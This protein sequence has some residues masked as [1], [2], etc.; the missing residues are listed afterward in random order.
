MREVQKAIKYLA[1]VFGLFL[2][3]NIIAW[4]IFGITLIGGTIEG[5]NYITSRADNTISYSETFENVQSL[6]IKLNA[7]ELEIKQGDCFKVEGNKISENAEIKLENS[8]LKITDERVNTSIWQNDNLSKI[9]VYIPEGTNL[10]SSNIKLGA[11]NAVIENIDSEK[12]DFEFGAGNVTL[13]NIYS[14]ESN[15][16]CGAGNIKVENSNL[17]NLKLKAGVGKLEYEGNISGDSK[18]ECGVGEIIL[19]LNEKIEKFT[20]KATK[21]LGELRINNSQISNDEVIGNGENTIK[22]EGGIGSIKIN[23]K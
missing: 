17:N 2:S 19:N 10:E 13:K 20:L 8:K 22:I 1:I 5:I 21:G 18:I 14:Q 3:V 15:I 9:I 4:T 12:F 11:G 7:S 23:T 16:T 6:E